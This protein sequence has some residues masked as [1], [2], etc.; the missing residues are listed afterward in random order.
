M[1]RPPA[2]VARSRIA[3][4]KDEL[5]LF[6]TRP[7]LTMRPYIPDLTLYWTAQGGAT[8]VADATGVAR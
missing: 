8:E 5:K 6:R 4:G 7:C 3:V 1:K 2:P